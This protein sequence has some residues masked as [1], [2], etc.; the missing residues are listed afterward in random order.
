MPIEY[1]QARPSDLEALLPLVEAFAREQESQMPINTLT[2]NF[3]QF[4][5]AGI[6]QAVQNPAGCVMVAEETEGDAAKMVGYAVG[7]AQEPPPIFEPVTYL[8]VSD[9]YVVPGHRR[10]GVGRALVE[11]VRGWGW[12]KGIYRVSLVLPTSSPAQELYAKLGFRPVQ[13]MLIE[14]GN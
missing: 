13:T 12:V 5:R 9:L 11:R 1:R 2:D 4:A 7:M 14:N 10:Q 6:A 8:F 3:M